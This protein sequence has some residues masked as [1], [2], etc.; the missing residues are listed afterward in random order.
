M[1]VY[2]VF[3]TNVLISSF[4]SKSDSP[5][6]ILIREYLFKDNYIVPVV[7]KDIIN[8]YKRVLNDKIL[9]N[10]LT[11]DEANIFL[12]ELIKKSIIIETDKEML[13]TPNVKHEDDKKFYYITL[14]AIEKIDKGTYLVS[15]NK[16]HFNFDIDFIVK[17]AE[18]VDIIKE[19]LSQK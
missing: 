12:S 9:E 10:M 16:K 18:M 4:V 5:V 8:E 11:S 14:E 2:A 17:P 1:I 19:K 3:D 6:N 13:D 7:S 15:G